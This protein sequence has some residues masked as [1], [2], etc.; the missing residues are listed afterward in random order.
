MIEIIEKRRQVGRD[1]AEA[2]GLSLL[3]ISLVED[4][5]ESVEE[6]SQSD[7]KLILILKKKAPQQL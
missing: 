6:I 1:L 3:D 2:L 5:G 4:L 7:G